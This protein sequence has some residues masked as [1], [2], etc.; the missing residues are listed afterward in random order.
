MTNVIHVGERREQV[1]QLIDDLLGRAMSQSWSK[2]IV[3]VE[4]FDDAKQFIRNVMK[5]IQEK[6]IAS[7]VRELGSM[8]VRFSNDSIIKAVRNSYMCCGE[9]ITD[10]VFFHCNC[11]DS[12][13]RLQDYLFTLNAVMRLKST[14]VCEW[15]CETLEEEDDNFVL[16]GG[17]KRLRKKNTKIS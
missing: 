12:S 5:I 2:I 17:K 8:E 14:P 11:D 1:S 3:M 6:G 9:T 7:N 10:A 15:F 16:Y 4:D 13:L